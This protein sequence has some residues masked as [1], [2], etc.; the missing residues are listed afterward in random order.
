MSTATLSD[1]PGTT[2]SGRRSPAIPSEVIGI[3][4]FVFTELMLFA[5]LISAF[6]IAQASAAVWP[7]MGQPRLPIEA[8][9]LNTAA[10]LASGLVLFFSR[11][12]V[13]RD[14][15]GTTTRMLTCLCLGAAFVLLQGSEW[16]ALLREGLTIRSSILGSFFYLIIGL[17][18]VHAVAGLGALLRTWRRFVSG[19][20]SPGSLAA[21][22]IFWL[23]V[24][25]LWPVLYLT[26]YR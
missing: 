11:R 6:R 3:F 22:E 2:P 17:H 4:L 20:G 7:P 26:V 15:A 5:G 21:A 12:A 14:P 13:R 10:L 8:T 18:A 23:F 19:T 16:V 24:V 9:A 25:G 1:A